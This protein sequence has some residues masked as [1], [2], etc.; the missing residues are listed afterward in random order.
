MPR[1]RWCS[2]PA[3]GQISLVLVKNTNTGTISFEVKLKMLFLQYTFNL[4]DEQLED[5]LI[6]RL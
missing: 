6:D 4:S 1:P 5:Q 2:S 3:T